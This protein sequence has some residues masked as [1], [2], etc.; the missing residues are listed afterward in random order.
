MDCEWEPFE[1]KFKCK[2]CGFVVPRDTIHKNCPI[3]K[4]KPKSPPSFSKRVAN[5]GKAGAKHLLT[6]RQHCTPEQR[7]E[8]FKICKSNKCGLFIP[9]GPGGM[10]SHDDCGCFIRSNG[11]FLDKLSWADSKC[12]VDEWGPI[13]TENDENGV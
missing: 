1:D 6:G 13:S 4:N 10:C 9:H 8:R 11:K 5:F 2:Y 3:K 7:R 12:P